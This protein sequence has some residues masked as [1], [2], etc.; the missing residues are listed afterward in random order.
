MKLLNKIYSLIIIVGFF[1]H[2]ALAEKLPFSVGE[3]LEYSAKFN[4][5]P[6]GKAFLTVVS[7]DT[8]NSLPAYH[9]RYEAQTG[10][11]ADKIYKIRNNVDSWLDE[12]EFFTHQQTKNIREGKY[13]FTSHTQIIY[14]HSIAI[15]NKDTIPIQ[16][17]LY[18]PYSL[19]YYFRTLKLIAEETIDLTVFDNK[20][21][22]EFQMIITSKEQVSVPAGTFDCM[23]VRPFR[24]GKTLLK[25]EGDMTIWFSNDIHKIPVQI[26]LKIKYGTMV[27]KLKTINL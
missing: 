21:L 24:E 16:S 18:D 5:I 22:T 27:M 15:V 10:P 2:Y 17:R 23:V 26:I 11:I 14:D 7:I 25:N 6:A 4:F 3:R 1:Y 19:F 20:S 9:V 13:R 12:K 8:I